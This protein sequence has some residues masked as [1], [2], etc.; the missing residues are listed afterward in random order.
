MSRLNRLFLG[1]SGAGLALALSSCASPQVASTC[2]IPANGTPAE[3][4][5][6]LSACF[7][8]SSN[9][10][11]DTTL[12]KNVDI[13]FMIDNSPSMSPKQSA[14]ANA[15]PGFIQA[16]DA[17][18]ADYHVGITTSDVGSWAQ[19]G[20][21]WSNLGSCDT[22]AGD[23]GTLQTT[24]CTN[25]MFTN[26]MAPTE[27]MTLCPDPSY[28]PTDGSGFI[29]KVNGVN[30]IKSTDPMAPQKAFQCMAMVGDQGCGIEGQ[31]EGAKRAL[32]KH[33]PANANFLRND[34]V[35]SVIFITDEDDCSVSP[36]GRPDN[37]PN[38]MDCSTPDP[39]APYS[40]YNPDYRCIAQDIECNE[41]LNQQGNKTGCQE[42]A[43]SYLNPVGTYVNFFGSLRP[44]SKLLM[45]GIWAPPVIPNALNNGANNS[46]QFNVVYANGGTT[47][48][49][50][51]RDV[52]M[53]AACYDVADSTIYARP[54]IRLSKFI[55]QF[56]DSI[57]QS[58]CD[59]GNYPAALANIATKIKTKLSAQCLNI[60]PKT[61][62]GK[63]GGA[64]LCLVGD[65]D[66]TNP[67]NAPTNP[68]PECNA[69]CCA[70]WAASSTPTA[71]DPTVMTACAS[72]TATACFCA[73]QSTA[74]PPECPGGVVAGIW[75]TTAA[76]ANKVT[77][78]RC[79]A[80]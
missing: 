4:N 9:N 68:F 53:N 43:S 36:S 72:E 25:R 3:R 51:N 44:T 38:T 58:I 31:L 18:G 62:N 2:A 45:S 14:L 70:G 42:R 80:Q 40:C 67:N 16:I 56:P 29:S 73:V 59:T 1:F 15:I 41:P 69:T 61:A 60:V 57:E 21:G 13:L 35:L 47:S 10:Y 7:S 12:Q 30:N 19:A 17:T 75:R 71:Q 32:D 50:L 63:P 65:V 27:C 39:N 46:G 34:S 52:N 48:D 20:S 5:A 37:D 74:N 22:F 6:A 64:P 24:A 55:A 26:P 66:D 23:D 49:T 11:V 77:N 76:P 28:L 79:A 8:A 33:N 54:Q 78:F